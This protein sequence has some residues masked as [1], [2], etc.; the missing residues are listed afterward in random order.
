MAFASTE[1]ELVLQATDNA[2]GTLK[3]VGGALTKFGKIAAAGAG[4]AGV[5]IGAA[6]IASVK[7]AAS[8]EK[9]MAEVASL[10]VPVD[11]MQTLE[12]GVLDLSKRLGVDATEATGALYQ[13]ISAG[14]PPENALAFLETA[15]KAAIAGVTDAE[16]AVDGISTVVNAFASQN[17]SAAEA[18]DLM[19]ATV[20]AGKTNFEE[21]SS[22]IANVAP[23]AN[24]TGVSF[25]EVSAALATMTA[26]GTATSVATTQVR[27]A[28]QALTKPSAELTDI[29]KQAGFESGEAAVRQIGFAKAADLV[30]QA[31]GG[32]VS[33]M[34]KLLGS[35]EGVQG[36][37]GVTGAQAETFANN[38]QG[39]RDS[40]GAADA[41][42]ETMSQSFD[43]QMNRVRESFKSGMIEVGLQILPILIP[44][45]EFIADKLPIAIEVTVG[46][47]T[48]F[49]DSTKAVVTEGQ[50][51]IEMVQLYGGV[52][53]FLKA[54]MDEMNSPFAFFIEFFEDDGMPAMRGFVDVLVV[55]HHAWERAA[56]IIDT[57]IKP[58]FDYLIE[59]TKP[60]IDS[61]K[62]LGETIGFSFS[63]IMETIKP[64]VP[65]LINLFL[66]VWAR[67]AQW[68][69]RLMPILQEFGRA[70]LPAVKTAIEKLTTAW[71]MFFGGPESD[72]DGSSM[73]ANLIEQ[74]KELAR[75]FAE[76]L[77]PFI[78]EMSD[79]FATI[80]PT[81]ATFVEKLQVIG[82]EILDNVGPALQEVGDV[83]TNVVMPALQPT[84]DLL[85]AIWEMFG[86]L[87]D[88]IKNVVVALVEGLKPI[89]DVLI[90]EVL[91]ILI[92]AWNKYMKL[93]K[94]E[95]LPVIEEV[96]IAIS[97]A[98][99]PAF[100]KISTI[101]TFLL[102]NVLVPYYQ[103]LVDFI[104]P[105]L[106]A[107]AKVVLGVVRDA[108]RIITKLLKGDFAGAFEAVG[109][110]LTNLRNGVAGIF[111][112]MVD[113]VFGAVRAIVGAVRGMAR[114]VASSV[115]DVPILGG[116]VGKLAGFQHGGQFTVGG[117]G[118]ADS[119]TVAFRAT[120]GETVT[121]TP[122][123]RRGGGGSIQNIIVQGSL[124]S[125]RELSQIIVDTVREQTRL[126][127]SILDVNAVTV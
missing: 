62:V 124:V 127:E 73:F 63:T 54:S 23:L 25:E 123:G 6:G 4:A 66:P 26:S 88:P 125:E 11:Q 93:F 103:F 117:A 126:N 1:L 30:S 77:G 74:G 37:L 71:E 91:P 82:Q 55:L 15:S 60:I 72:P 45:A 32:S 108:F 86:R 78:D 97:E 80:I 20:K 69:G 68:L 59:A 58:A 33:E 47:I 28:I 56:E 70:I 76:K 111:Q 96:V 50:S 107:V 64:L 114:D 2:S 12:A 10:G 75:T 100:D 17:L 105:I 119:Q 89:L 36:V 83:L 81:I 121:V 9:A 49:I 41:A 43:H 39:M 34:T 106:V 31:T 112:S 109:T 16:T 18:A 53:G 122:A 27:S 7:M 35:I 113:A 21:L 38:M 67:L 104:I 13:A 3:K 110:L 61:F 24:A 85:V 120:P 44:I 65:I 87:V 46:A 99:V 94:E 40:A 90:T 79:K 19:F 51:F 52:L 116:V 14:V 5:A 118:G 98:L 84:I 48:R 101:V 95:L 92:E 102:K 29:F 115:K 8:Y 57:M 42:F 22:S